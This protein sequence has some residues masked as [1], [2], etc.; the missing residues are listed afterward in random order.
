MA[1][2]RSELV[3][4]RRAADHL[5]RGSD[6][7]GESGSRR[8]SC[9]AGGSGGSPA[10]AAAATPGNGLASLATELILAVVFVVQLSDTSHDTDL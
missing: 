2:S 6:D 9:L 8:R 3:V 1:G 4:D 5:R 7:S 10:A